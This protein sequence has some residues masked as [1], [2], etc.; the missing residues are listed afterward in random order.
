[1]NGIKK[2]TEVQQYKQFST[3]KFNIRRL[4]IKRQPDGWSGGFWSLLARHNILYLL[5]EK[6]KFNDEFFI[7]YGRIIKIDKMM[8]GEVSVIR[9]TLLQITTFMAKDIS[10]KTPVPAREAHYSFDN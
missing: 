8:E 1:M 6:L 7:K 2:D 10:S 3:N 5:S 9:K 4:E